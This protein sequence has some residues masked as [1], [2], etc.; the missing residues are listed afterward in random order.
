MQTVIMVVVIMVVM[1]CVMMKNILYS[2]KVMLV[3]LRMARKEEGC[4]EREMAQA[5]REAK[6][7]E[8]TEKL[9]AAANILLEKNLDRCSL[10]G[11]IL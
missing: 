8:R 3:H 10:L 5:D 4:R 11:P 6:K 9:K 2:V 1:V 7:Q